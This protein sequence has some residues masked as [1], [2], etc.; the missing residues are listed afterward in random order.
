LVE[1]FNAI[2]NFFHGSFFAP[3]DTCRSDGFYYVEILTGKKTFAKFGKSPKSLREM[4][5]ALQ[6]RWAKIVKIYGGLQLKYSTP[7]GYKA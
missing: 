6:G 4:Q 2:S 7:I 1:F 3:D 5:E